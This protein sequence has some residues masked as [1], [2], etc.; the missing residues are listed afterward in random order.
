MIAPTT[1]KRRVMQRLACDSAIVHTNTSYF[2]MWQKKKV[3]GQ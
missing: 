2:A 1:T 3:N